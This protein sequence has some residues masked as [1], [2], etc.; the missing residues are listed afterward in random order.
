MSLGRS[1]ALRHLR[2]HPF[3]RGLDDAFVE[4]IGEG[5][6]E[7]NFATGAQVI[8][9]GDVANEMLLVVHGKVA[10]E[11]IAPDRP[12]L[13]LLTVGPGE[14]I[15]WSWLLPPHRW[16][17]DGRALKPTL[18]LSTEAS[19]LRKLMEADPSNAYAFMLRL[20]PVMNARLETARIQVMDIHGT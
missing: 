3:M 5:T 7:R 11:M 9:E 1:E 15:G 18:V 14:L 2:D 4:A 12:R 16:N 13:S 10:L 19:H 17:V 8:R 20:L 6:R